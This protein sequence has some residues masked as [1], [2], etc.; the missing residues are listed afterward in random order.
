M[1][2]SILG[3]VQAVG[4]RGLMLPVGS[5]CMGKE[6]RGLVG[7]PPGVVGRCSFL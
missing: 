6:L 1:S 5:P 4:W 7:V 3:R 2:V